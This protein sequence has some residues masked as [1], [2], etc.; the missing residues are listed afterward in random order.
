MREQREIFLFMQLLHWLWLVK[1]SSSQQGSFHDKRDNVNNIIS[2][3]FV[4]FE[5]MATTVLEIIHAIQE[6]LAALLT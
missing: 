5:R 6:V 2:I 3:T 1:G 4:S